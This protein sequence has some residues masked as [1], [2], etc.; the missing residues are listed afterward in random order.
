MTLLNAPLQP[1]QVARLSKR[2]KKL[3]NL[4]K[5]KFEVIQKMISK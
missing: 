1:N 4:Q 3:Y 2:E 5:G